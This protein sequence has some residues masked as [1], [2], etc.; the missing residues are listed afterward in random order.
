MVTSFLAMIVFTMVTFI[1]IIAKYFIAKD[2]NIAQLRMLMISFISF[3]FISQFFLNYM[4]TSQLCGKAQPK[5][6]FL[7]TVIPWLFIFGSIVFLLEMFPGWKSPF[8]NTFG[9]LVVVLMGIKGVFQKMM[10]SKY[11]NKMVEAIYNDK[12]MLINEFTPSNFQDLYEKNLRDGIFTSDAKKY[13]TQFSNMVR[14]KD[15]IAEFIWYILTGGLII[16]ISYNSM[17]GAKC[18]KDAET[19]KQEHRKWEA[20]KNKEEKKEEPEKYIVRD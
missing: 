17:S 11:T 18:F 19:M 15:Y 13:K 20:E 8:S 4:A 1:N 10:P 9:Y 12:S 2:N 7:N 3:V 16:A 14:L 6:A 5:I